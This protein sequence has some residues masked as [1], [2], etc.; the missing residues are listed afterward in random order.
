MEFTIIL[1][2]FV[3]MYGLTHFEKESGK[4]G[5]ILCCAL[6]PKY[7]KAAKNNMS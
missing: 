6:D 5:I 3:S 1:C 7:A 2:G 4:V